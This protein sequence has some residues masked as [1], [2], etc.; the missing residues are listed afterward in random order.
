MGRKVN[1]IGFRL[2]VV[3]D[4]ES[5]WYA[6]RT[7]TEQLHEDIK[8]RDLIMKE[9]T[10]ASISKIELER[11]RR[12]RSMRQIA[13]GQTGH[14]H[15]RGANVER[16]PQPAREELQQEGLTSA[17]RRSRRRKPTRA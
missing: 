1:P 13:H 17:S 9:L 15:R 2:G 16:S 5:K 8:I 12:T 10:R 7:Y 11:S 3:S 4:W 14:C 6:E